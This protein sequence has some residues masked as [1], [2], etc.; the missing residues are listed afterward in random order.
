MTMHNPM[1]D[2]TLICLCQDCFK[3]CPQLDVVLNGTY[4][5]GYIPNE[6]ELAY[7]RKVRDGSVAFLPSVVAS[8]H[9]S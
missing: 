3:N 7:I 9:H 8:W 6:A 2:H 5:M 1:I 4:N